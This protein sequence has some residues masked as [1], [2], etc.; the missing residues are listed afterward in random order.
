MYMYVLHRHMYVYVCMLD[1]INVYIMDG[2]YAEYYYINI[3]M[4]KQIY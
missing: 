4:Y 3:M 2:V 1:N